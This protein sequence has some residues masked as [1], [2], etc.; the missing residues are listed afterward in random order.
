MNGF[1][2]RS[3]CHNATARSC[4]FTLREIKLHLEK[5]VPGL[6]DA[7]MSRKTIHHLMVPPR[8]NTKAANLYKGLIMARI[9]KKKSD[10]KFDHQDL[11]FYRAQVGYF[12]VAAELF[13]EDPI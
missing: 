1:A 12:F 8:K 6:K 4:G 10:M 13:K 9:P 3:R 7:G 11:H 5:T 2:A